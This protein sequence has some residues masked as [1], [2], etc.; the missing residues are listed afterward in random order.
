MGDVLRNKGKTVT[1]NDENVLGDTNFNF[2]TIKKGWNDWKIRGVS[3]YEF[4][5]DFRFLY[6]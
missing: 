5:I 6:D 1:L 2:L 4:K 3:N